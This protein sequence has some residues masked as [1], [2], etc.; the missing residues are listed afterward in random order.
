M[1]PTRTPSAKLM[2]ASVMAISIIVLSACNTV[3]GVGE[4]LS[5]AG[6]AIGETA[7]KTKDKM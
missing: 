2:F 3:Q 5:K 4:D 6:A 1:T 7:K